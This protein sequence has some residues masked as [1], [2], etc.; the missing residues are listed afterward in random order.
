MKVL[1][2]GATGFVGSHL[3]A[4]LVQRGDEVHCLSRRPEP[5]AFL[6]SLGGLVAPGS[7]EDAA[8]LEAA[9]RGMDVVYHLA[10]LTAAGSEREF[11]DVN[12][13]GTARL[14]AAVRNAAP[15]LGRFVH[16]SS[17]AAVGPTAPR[18]AAHRGLPVPPGDGVRPEQAGRRGSGARRGRAAR[19]PSC[20]RRRCT[21]RATA[22]SCACSG[23]RGAGSPRSSGWAARSCRSS[24]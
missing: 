15:R 6:A 17:I 9:V 12:E 19:G 7:L 16:V 22:S 20:A 24:T 2:T 18:P 8:S 14:V 3:A 5:A 1:V 21:G 23:S 4:A 13:A 11:L 10:G